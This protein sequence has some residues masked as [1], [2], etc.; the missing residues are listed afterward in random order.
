MCNKS[1][2]YLVFFF[3]VLGVSSE[4]FASFGNRVAG[5]LQENK[6]NKNDLSDYTGS[7]GSESENDLDPKQKIEKKVEGYE[8][9]IHIESPE[10]NAID[11]TNLKIKTDGL[12]E[13]SILDFL[14][15]PLKEENKTSGETIPFSLSKKLYQ[16]E[17]IKGYYPIKENCVKVK[18]LSEDTGS[19]SE[20]VFL[21]SVNMGSKCLG[22]RQEDTWK[23]ALIFKELK[24]ADP[25]NSNLLFTYPADREIQNLQDIM[26]GQRENAPK[27]GQGLTDQIQNFPI[28]SYPEAFFSFKR[29]NLL[30][31]NSS[32]SKNQSKKMNKSNSGSYV[33]HEAKSFNKNKVKPLFSEPYE[34]SPD[35]NEN[36]MSKQKSFIADYEDSFTDTNSINNSIDANILEDEDNKQETESTKHYFIIMHA[37]QGD[38]LKN[39]TLK[40][41][42][43]KRSSFD[44]Y[45]NNQKLKNLDDIYKE[46]GKT[47][48]NFH[49]ALMSPETFPTLNNI[50]D[51]TT[52]LVNHDDSFDKYFQT[53][54]H[55]DLH[56]GNVMVND[57]RE[58][59][60]TQDQ[61]VKATL[62][63]PFDFRFYFIDLES[64]S[65]SLKKKSPILVDLS[66][67][68]L[69][70]LGENKIKETPPD[71]L[72]I[73]ASLLKSFFDG[74]VGS[75][76]T[77]IQ[78]KLKTYIKLG[79][80]RNRNMYN[81]FNFE[82]RVK[83]SE[84]G[85]Y[86]D[87]VMQSLNVQDKN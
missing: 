12:T 47:L 20:K 35:V 33:D 18:K 82:K 71:T 54:V 77:G 25:E 46:F 74:Y 23:N 59:I 38:G 41:I 43:E 5:T 37:A 58:K 48:A 15:Y 27:L 39:Y 68:F 29:I 64:M 3:T 75:Y 83:S 67:F 44:N 11:V 30:I 22:I 2:L 24:I 84:G 87:Y 53:I 21:V 40:T 79:L 61:S 49:L 57:L 76:P 63:S 7:L 55:G 45:L 81:P 6:G 26:N 80:L 85:L 13:E 73:Y 10:P 56:W 32:N 60:W 16:P 31:E 66:R 72:N 65:S 14:K 69:F 1:W 51:F 78:D 62:K 28:F 52:E 8:A 17:A 70:I 50:K 4:S 19:F 86:R 42:N 9:E 34:V 36:A